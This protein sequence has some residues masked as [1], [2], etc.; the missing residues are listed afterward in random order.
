MSNHTDQFV[1]SFLPV[2]CVI[3]FQFCP[4]KFEYFKKMCSISQF[5][6]LIKD[7]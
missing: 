5:D 3:Q 7:E 6:N 4:K 1:E 2:T